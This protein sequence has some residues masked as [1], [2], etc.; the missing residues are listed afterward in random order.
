MLHLR[1]IAPTD[2]RE[3]V[4]DLLTKNPGV[5]HIVAHRDR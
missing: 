1:V 4:L 5:T 2:L 3:P